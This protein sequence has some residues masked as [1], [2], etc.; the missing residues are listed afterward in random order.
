MPLESVFYLK[1]VK[2][3]CVILLGMTH[4]LVDLTKD[5][6]VSFNLVLSI[7]R[8]NCLIVEASRASS[9][10]DFF[11]NQC[12]IT[13]FVGKQVC[14]L[15]F[16]EVLTIAT[17]WSHW[18]VTG[19]GLW[20][21]PSHSAM[22]LSSSDRVPTKP[23]SGAFMHRVRPEI[24]GNNKKVRLSYLTAIDESHCLQTPT[25]TKTFWIKS[26]IV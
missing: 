13:P 6:I 1:T 19:C 22:H 26:M 11:T 18:L 21:L 16:E 2:V 23:P 24:N 3:C 25:R 17:A 8:R 14:R 7:R 12:I 4:G 10:H 9:I 20:S 15:V 5:T